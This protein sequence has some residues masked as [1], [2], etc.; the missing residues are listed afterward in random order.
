MPDAALI[1]LLIAVLFG[2]WLAVLHFAG[3]SSERTP[4]P[5]AMMHAVLALTGLVLLA[6]TLRGPARGAD[7]GMAAFGFIAVGLLVVAA[8]VGA[9][10]FVRFRLRRKGASTLV[11]IHAALAVSGLVILAAYVLS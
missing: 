3:R 8:I 7:Q 9:Q 1:L 10:I 5:L 2:S 4:W 11:G 6:V